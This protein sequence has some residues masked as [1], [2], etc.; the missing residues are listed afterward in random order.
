MD[1]VRRWLPTVVVAVSVAAMLVH[2]RIPQL[3]H[4]HE[5][6][7][8][9][10]LADLPNALNVLS[11]I[12]FAAIGLWG[13]AALRHRRDDPALAGAWAGYVTFFAA[14]FLT[15]FGSSFYH[16]APG[17]DRLVWDRLPIAL[18]CAGLLAAVRA[19][20]H[21]SQSRAVLPAL[22]VAAVASVFWW[23]FTDSL[24]RDDLRPYLLLQGAPL[25]L[26]PLW[27]WD[28][29]SPRDD[30]LAFG[31]AILLYAIAK[32]FE[33]RDHATLDALGFVSGHT[34]KH[35]LATLAGAVLTWNVVRKLSSSRPVA[36]NFVEA[37]GEP[38]C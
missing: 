38:Q 18:A 10:A 26:I 20:T 30:R 12:G 23:S 16:L 28:A 21:P 5:F 29:R 14:L 37:R 31:A 34:I 13:L 35:L 33:L 32:V 11:N 7:D 17:N 25:A 24:G 22:I 36:R 3:A 15:A 6:A 19:E 27:Q 4:Y 9:R 8:T 2:G 1:Q